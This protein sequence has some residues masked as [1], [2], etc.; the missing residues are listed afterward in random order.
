MFCAPALT[1]QRVFCLL[2]V[3]AWQV[4][5]GK[6][7]FFIVRTRILLQAKPILFLQ[8]DHLH[9]KLSAAPVQTSHC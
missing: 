6:T 4:V 8:F 1:A 3:L 5:G 9:T 2:C 7:V